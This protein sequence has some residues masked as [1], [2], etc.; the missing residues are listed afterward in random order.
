MFTLFIVFGSLIPRLV[1]FFKF[2]GMNIRSVCWYI[3]IVCYVSYRLSV[4]LGKS[5]DCQ[6]HVHVEGLL[7]S[8]TCVVLLSVTVD[9]ED[10]SCTW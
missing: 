10:T 7:I 3:L 9:C 8:L 5:E 1:Q 4:K 2:N 6:C